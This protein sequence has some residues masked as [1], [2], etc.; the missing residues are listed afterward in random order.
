MKGNI[1]IIKKVFI[2][3]LFTI[4]FINSSAEPYKPYP[5]L[6]IHGI[7]SNSGTWGAN[8]ENRSDSIPADSVQD[9]S[10]DYPTYA[11][12]LGYMNPYAVAWKSVDGSYT[13]PGDDAFPNKT[14]LEVI[15]FDDN[16]G[17]IDPH[18]NYP[19]FDGQGDE[20]WHRIN[21]VMEEYYGEGWRNNRNA[22]IILVAH[23][24]GGLSVREC[25]YA[26]ADVLKPHIAKVITL[27]SPHV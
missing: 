4:F 3:Q 17:S 19:N 20:L 6:L 16:R 11:Y 2:I 15:N 25:I 8:T 23:S 18:P 24:A 7:N 9:K 10:S 1:N 26:H 5:I 22:K 21:E 27:G 13:I 12:F 14:F